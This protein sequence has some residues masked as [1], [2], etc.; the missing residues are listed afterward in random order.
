MNNQAL[1]T[2]DKLFLQGVGQPDLGADAD[3]ARYKGSALYRSLKHLQT[4]PDNTLILPGRTSE[5]IA[6]DQRLVASPLANVKQHTQALHLD[7]S[8]FIETILERIPPTPPNYQH[9][10]EL[11]EAG[12]LPDNPIELEAG[13]NRCAIG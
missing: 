3:G 1:F 4:F 10:V 5:P 11:N 6:F 8:A 7:E 9:I 13:A 12:K 2:G